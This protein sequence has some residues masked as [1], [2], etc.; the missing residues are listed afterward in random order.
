MTRP[1]AVYLRPLILFI[2]LLTIVLHVAACSKPSPVQQDQTSQSIDQNEQDVLQTETD[3]QRHVPVASIDWSEHEPNRITAGR[4]P[5]WSPLGHWLTYIDEQERLVL[6]PHQSPGA[7]ARVL[8]PK[9]ETQGDDIYGIGGYVWHPDEQSLIYYMNTTPDSRAATIYRRSVQGGPR[10]TVVQAQAGSIVTDLYLTELGIHYSLLEQE[11]QFTI[12]A[13]GSVEELEK[14]SL[15]LRFAPDGTGYI[16]FSSGRPR[17]QRL[18]DDETTNRWE[19]ALAEIVEKPYY[20][21]LGA[22]WSGDG[23]ALAVFRDEDVWLYWFENEE[24]SSGSSTNAS[25]HSLH[26][27]MPGQA[28]VQDVIWSNHGRQ[29][30]ILA[31]NVESS[32]YAL[33]WMDAAEAEQTGAT[34]NGPKQLSLGPTSSVTWSPDGQYLVYDEGGYLYVRTPRDDFAFDIAD[35]SD[36]DE[37]GAMSV[38]SV[39][40]GPEDGLVQASLSGAQEI[41][42][43]STMAEDILRNIE[44]YFADKDMEGQAQSERLYR[45]SNGNIYAVIFLS[46]S[47]TGDIPRVERYEVLLQPNSG[48]FTVLAAEIWPK[49]S[50][51]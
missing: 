19:Q 21:S 45:L 35:L 2:S 5:V 41:Q 44:R 22:R 39:N 18:Q 40:T 43:G 38:E 7:K 9:L 23:Q 24:S 50:V 8:I 17:W 12:A 4:M 14:G 48:E 37:P 20:T 29:L 31:Q 11:K 32:G 15:L 1:D 33:W 30:G 46:M 26:V 51:H 28:I 6:V 25:L 3:E 13:D 16:E 27:S 34:E 49:T 10:E 42:P 47:G 36:E